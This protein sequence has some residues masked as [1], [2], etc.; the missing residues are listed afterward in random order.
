MKGR[1]MYL[2]RAVDARGQ[3]IDLL[4]SRCLRRAALLSQG[5]EAGAHGQP[6]HPHRRIRTPPTG[7]QQGDEG[8][9]R[10]VALRQA[11]TM[12]VF[13]QHC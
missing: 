6:G 3:T 8:G 2:Y 4:L 13:E 12:Q 1:W 5:A 11:S 10:D 9:R 7:V